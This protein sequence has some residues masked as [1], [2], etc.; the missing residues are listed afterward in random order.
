VLTFTASEFGRKLNENGDGTDHG[1]GGHHFVMGAGVKGGVYGYFPDLSTWNEA[2]A[3]YGDD[4]VMPDGTL[5]PS[6]PVDL[7]AKELGQW[8][9]VN[10]SEG[11]N[12]QVAQILFPNLDPGKPL[13]GFTA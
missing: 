3:A 8:L 11:S 7:Y 13:M 2:K 4:Q 6:I 10:W 9:G 12:Q 1:W 5:V